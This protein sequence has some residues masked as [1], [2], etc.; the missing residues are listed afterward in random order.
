MESLLC[1]VCNST[2]QSKYGLNNI[3]IYKCANCGHYYSLH[4]IISDD[5]YTK[6]YFNEKHKNWFAHPD[7]KLF[8]F[9]VDHITARCSY[10]VRILDVGCGNGNLLRYLKLKGFTNLFGLDLYD[11]KIP[12]ITFYNEKIEDFICNQK[13]EVIVTVM[14]IEHIDNVQQFFKKIRDLSTPNTILIINT[15]DSSSLIYGL[16]KYL[17]YLGIETLFKRLYDVHHLNH[18]SEKSLKYLCQANGFKIEKLLK[19][20][21]PLKSI[22]LS[23]KILIIMVAFLNLMS[24]LFNKEISQV[25]F[26][27][28]CVSPN[29][30]GKKS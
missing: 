22:D 10:D 3:T 9:I 27:S 11:N 26:L 25:L 12:G 17:K 7:T 29:S 18:F 8:D 4:P 15:I 14:T 21:Y 19:K 30:T 6:E 5:I 2:T 28:N 20:N 1:K 13:Y 16:A 24:T 23:P